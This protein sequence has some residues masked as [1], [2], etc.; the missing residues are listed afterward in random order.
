MV[1][2]NKPVN[3][4]IPSEPPQLVGLLLVPKAMVGAVGCAL[5]TTFADAPD[6]QPTSFVTVKL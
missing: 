2:A 4:I 6:V 1:L 5:I 3:L